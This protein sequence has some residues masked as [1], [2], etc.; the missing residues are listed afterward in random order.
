M[1]VLIDCEVLG[2]ADTSMA[3]VGLDDDE[4]ESVKVD[5][6][7]PPTRVQGDRTAKRVLIL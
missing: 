2:L 6:L 7:G 1:T 5:T 4:R 3:L